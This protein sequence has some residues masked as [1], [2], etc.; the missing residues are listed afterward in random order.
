[1]SHRSV[2]ELSD[3][4][5]HLDLRSLQI[6]RSIVETGSLTEAAVRE[7]L[8]VSAVSR[9]VAALEQLLGEPLLERSRDGVAPTSAGLELVER[10]DELFDVLG[11]LHK[12]AKAHRSG[13]RGEVRL[14][15]NASALADVL[16][17]R[18]ASFMR[19]HPSVVLNLKQSDSVQVVRS[20]RG[21]DAHIG[22]FSSYASAD[23]LETFVLTKTRLVVIVP[24]GHPLAKRKSTTFAD[25]L[26]YDYVVLQDGH[27]LSALLTHM[28]RIARRLPS[29]M[30][31]RAKAA[32][33]RVACRFVEAG[34]GITLAPAT[35][36]QLYSEKLN[37]AVINLSDEWAAI[38]H[39]ICV[40]D[41]ALLP[42]AARNFLDYLVRSGARGGP[43]AG[44]EPPSAP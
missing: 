37:L 26:G 11:R 9:R 39:D 34:L 16:P 6:F 38:R 20:V 19:E 10:I 7:H 43:H 22:V 15:S 28:L 3:L 40:R 29:P 41:R 17:A 32:D 4:A 33:V 25:T 21:G 35:S 1:M 31:I 30:R 13:L 5:G 12:D 36:A 8:V 14:Q 24:V 42:A 18:I 44:I 27:S 23:G 2:K